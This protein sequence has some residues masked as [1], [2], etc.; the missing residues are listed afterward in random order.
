MGNERL[1]NIQKMRTHQD[2]AKI[3]GMIFQESLQGENTQRTF[4]GRM[5]PG[6][7]SDGGEN[8]HTSTFYLIGEEVETP[9]KGL[10]KL[11]LGKSKKKLKVLVE[12]NRHYLT[13]G[14]AIIR[15]TNLRE[16]TEKIMTE[17]DERSGEKY[18]SNIRYSTEEDFFELEQVKMPSCSGHFL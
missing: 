1:E 17:Q 6:Y 13:G 8:Y 14:S 16:S 12:L 3:Y 15:D 10:S 9:R 18:S 4:V 7:S 5:T 11:L 2:K